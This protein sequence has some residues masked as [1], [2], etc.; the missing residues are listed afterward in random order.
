MFRLV[1]KTDVM[2]RSLFISDVEKDP[3]AIVVGGFGSVFKGKRGGQLVA[4]KMLYRGHHPGVRGFLLVSPTPN[5]NLIGKDS[6]E[7]EFYTEALA[8]R[9]LSHRFILPL[10]GIYK[11]GPQ[12]LLV[13]TIY[14]E[15]SIT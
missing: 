7:K 1:S 15:W 5:V 12:L 13:S 11:E 10:L 6:I 9:S 3:G 2:P 4:L 8:W 14:D